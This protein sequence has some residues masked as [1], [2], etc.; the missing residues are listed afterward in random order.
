MKD[1]ASKQ[2]RLEDPTFRSRAPEHIV[3]GLES[4]LAERQAE[5]AKLKERLATL[6]KNL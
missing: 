5:L 3:K 1:I 4:T 2:L 6:E